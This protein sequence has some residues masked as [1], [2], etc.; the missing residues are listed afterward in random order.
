ML[1]R[2]LS[3]AQH[4]S[5]MGLWLLIPM[6]GL[7]SLSAWGVSLG[8]LDVSV[9]PAAVGGREGLARTLQPELR[10]A[11]G[12]A[13]LPLLGGILAIA[14][15]SV[16]WHGRQLCREL[17]L[18]TSRIKGAGS[19][20]PPASCFAV[21]EFD[22]INRAFDMIANEHLREEGRAEF[23]ALE[24]QHRTNNLLTVVSSIAR[25]TF[26]G[27][28]PLSEARELFL[29]R[30]HALANATAT[31]ADAKWKGAELDAVVAK[32]LSHYPGRY[33]ASG[34]K[35]MLS[36]AIAQSV[37]LL[38]HELA[39]NARRYGAFSNDAGFVAVSWRYDDPGSRRLAFEWRERGGPLVAPPE[40]RGFGHKLLRTR[41]SDDGAP[42]L[43]FDAE[44]FT[45]RAQL[46]LDRRAS[47]AP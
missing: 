28:R 12:L 42:A 47:K 20:S 32:E 19:S 44:G 6:V 17:D 29:G 11:G 3:F 41:L 14:A 1:T 23:L 39:T 45:Y 33:A 16:F 10:S 9:A 21:R 35:V 7:I 36:P 27:G 5:L 13:S 8:W 40:R 46:P 38:I 30:L 34:P 43:I 18:L 22:Q 2:R 24:L 4:L 15:F 26:V 25:H 37:S 31:L